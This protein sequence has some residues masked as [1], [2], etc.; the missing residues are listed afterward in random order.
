[1]S[2]HFVGILLDTP[3]NNEIKEPELLKPLDLERG[4]QQSLQEKICFICGKGPEFHYP[5]N[6][7]SEEQKYQLE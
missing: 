6:Y 7:G 4:D 3:K 5:V 1:M 2:H